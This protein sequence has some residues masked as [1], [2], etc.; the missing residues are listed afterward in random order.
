[1]PRRLSSAAW[2]RTPAARRRPPPPRRAKSGTRRIR[3]GS[4]PPARIPARGSMADRRQGTAE[5]LPR[6]TNPARSKMSAPP[7][8]LLLISGRLP[9]NAGSPA[10]AG[11][12]FPMAVVEARESLPRGGSS[13]PPQRA[14]RRRKRGRAPATA[15]HPCAR[16]I[17]G[18]FFPY[19][20]AWPW[21]KRRP[22]TGEGGPLP[23]HR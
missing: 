21:R 2:R 19:F 17:R 3:R 11:W 7:L 14:P 16:R 1:L 15:L 9:P 5:K 13:A 6:Q 12:S 22:K 10:V 18:P 4:L 23:L 8:R 20:V